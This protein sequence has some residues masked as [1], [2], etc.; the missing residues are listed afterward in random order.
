MCID[1]LHTLGE[2]FDVGKLMIAGLLP[3]QMTED[4]HNE[5]QA[6]VQDWKQ[7]ATLEREKH[8]ERIFDYLMVTVPLNA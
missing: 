8:L 4:I 7:N 2:L 1:A 5:L 6:L 3:D